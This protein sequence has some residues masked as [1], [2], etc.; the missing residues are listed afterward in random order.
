[1]KKYLGNIVKRSKVLFFESQVVALSSN[2]V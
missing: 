2:L 1:M